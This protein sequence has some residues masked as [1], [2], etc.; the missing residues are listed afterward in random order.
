MSRNS[1]ERQLN[2]IFPIKHSTAEMFTDD[3]ITSQ[4]RGTPPNHSTAVNNSS[5]TLMRSEVDSLNSRLQRLNAENDELL[6]KLSESKRWRERRER[7][8][9]DEKEILLNKIEMLE[10]KYTESVKDLKGVKHNLKGYEEL[11]DQLADIRNRLSASERERV[12]AERNEEQMRQ[13]MEYEFTH[14]DEEEMEMRR[15]E[16]DFER[17]LENI[18]RD[19]DV[20]V[21]EL[22]AEVKRL[23]DK[24]KSNT[25]IIDELKALNDKHTKDHGQVKDVE[26]SEAT[27]ERKELKRVLEV[28]VK[29]RRQAV[30]EVETLKQELELNSKDASKE[31]TR[32]C[33]LLYQRELQL[34]ESEQQV[35]V[36]QGDGRSPN[37]FKINNMESPTGKENKLEAAIDRL[38]D[39]EAEHRIL[40]LRSK[41]QEL[42]QMLAR[43]KLEHADELERLKVGCEQKE[44]L[45]EERIKQLSDITDS[46]P[47]GDSSGLL[48]AN[49]ELTENIRLKNRELEILR[50][51]FESCQD[52]LAKVK[53]E[54]QVSVL[55]QNVTS[56][57][58][59]SADKQLLKTIEIKDKEL[60]IA[61]EALEKSKKELEQARLVTNS[62][63]TADSDSR[64]LVAENERLVKK[65][66]KKS[67]RLKALKDEEKK[68]DDERASSSSD[69]RQNSKLRSAN[70]AL[71]S[72]VLKLDSCLQDLAASR[73]ELDVCSLEKDRLKKELE[74][75]KLEID[76]LKLNIN[77]HHNTES[78]VVSKELLE[79][80]ERNGKLER[81][82]IRLKLEVDDLKAG[83]ENKNGDAMKRLLEEKESLIVD[84]MKEVNKLRAALIKNTTDAV[85][86]KDE[87]QKVGLSVDNH[88][89]IA[90]DVLQ[91]KYED[92]LSAHRKLL[93]ES[94][95]HRADQQ[96]IQEVSKV[97]ESRDVSVRKELNHAKKKLESSEERIAQLESWLDEIYS[98]PEI[99]LAPVTRRSYGVGSGLVEPVRFPDLNQSSVTDKAY[100]SPRDTVGERKKTRVGAAKPLWD[101]RPKK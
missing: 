7:D 93:E 72:N 30:L 24:L 98:D 22:H 9:S 55:A 66:L 80:T 63:T 75:C 57:R 19:Y 65:V 94:I 82:L 32:L 88:S 4:K 97:S 76:V 86:N 77:N 21:T 23:K 17:H 37:Q 73:K 52:D 11:Q 44:E 69:Q 92:I 49:K 99:G 83:K 2:L 43:K 81:A 13:R 14:R 1:G 74:S 95:G 10:S 39:P 85:E 16:G 78:A 35:R 53:D 31:M 50:G 100:R 64:N 87:K 47:P 41:V 34:E 96:V 101:P 59:N 25:T 68:R 84:L 61:H 51:C 5:N 18:R 29:K 6:D 60:K 54:L 56:E 70:E 45:L 8:F 67:K 91:H 15:A 62:T 33:D 27:A 36:H 46:V 20:I 79:L 28:E 90:F 40:T 42:E 38:K 48:K 58:P 89:S 26:L 3:G 12:N 71:S